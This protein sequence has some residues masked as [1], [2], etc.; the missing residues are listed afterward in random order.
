MKKTRRNINKK[1]GGEKHTI[2]KLQIKK[3]SKNV[4][5]NSYNY[6]KTNKNA[7]RKFIEEKMRERHFLNEEDKILWSSNSFGTSH[8]TTG[9]GPYA[10]VLSDEN[11]KHKH[12]IYKEQ[13]NQFNVALGHLNY[14]LKK[15]ETNKKWVI[16][17]SIGSYNSSASIETSIK[18]QFPNEIENLGESH[19]I[20]VMLIDVEFL[21]IHRPKTQIYDWFNLGLDE[22]FPYNCED[23]VE[24]VRIWKK[25]KMFEKKVTISYLDQTRTLNTPKHDFYVVTVPVSIH[26]AMYDG[27]P[28]NA[29]LKKS[30][31]FNPIIKWFDERYFPEN[32]Y[33]T[34]IT[35]ENAITQITKDVDV[36]ELIFIGQTWTGANRIAL[37]LSKEKEI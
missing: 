33:T 2:R 14:C 36:D 29:N 25:P 1:V 9:F 22:T 32:N 30:V 20:V 27:Y 34:G 23:N 10:L 24:C 18:Q 19:N 3:G 5:L 35:I 26:S 13:L 8:K 28:I 11:I 16:F 31:L 7:N 15:N 12:D 6:N 21:N 4:Y 17:V 37:K